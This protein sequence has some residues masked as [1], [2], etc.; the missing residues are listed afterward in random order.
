MVAAQVCGG[1]DSGEQVGQVRVSEWHQG[2]GQ[3]TGVLDCGNGREVYIITMSHF[4]T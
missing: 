2:L 4:D 1:G 3:A